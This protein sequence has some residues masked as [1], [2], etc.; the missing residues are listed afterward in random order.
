MKQY[1]GMP[2]QE[3]YE[4]YGYAFNRYFDQLLEDEGG[5][6]PTKRAKKIKD[7]GG[8]TNYGISLRFLKSCSI[9]VADLNNDGVIDEKDIMIL[10]PVQAKTLY[11]KYFWN[12]LYP[13]IRNIQLENRLFN[14]GVNIGRATAVKILQ[15]SINKVIQTKLLK[16]D[17]RFGRKTL[18][19]VKNVNQEKL[20]QQ[21]IIDAEDYYRSLN[22][23]QFING[24]LR[25]L[26]KLLP[27]TTVQK[28]KDWRDRQYERKQNKMV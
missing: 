7:P 3:Y 13:E 10:T 6:V 21:F 2:Y 27:D 8:A 1:F 5:Y 15:H 11:F 4:T 17:G 20:Y 22:K 24:W 19:A 23:P 16:P 25:R 26:S 12:P 18:A 14:L 28:I 9:D